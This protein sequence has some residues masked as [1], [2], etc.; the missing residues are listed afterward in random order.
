MLKPLLFQNIHVH[1]VDLSKPRSVCQFAAEFMTRHE[2]LDVLVNNAGC[3][4]PRAVDADGIETNFATNS[5]APFILT[6][7]LNPLLHK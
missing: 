7:L 1:L 4:V 2:R 3:M 6:Q 5:L